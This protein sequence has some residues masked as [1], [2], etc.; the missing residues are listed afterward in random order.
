MRRALVPV[1][2]LAVLTAAALPAT[3]AARP[4]K[5]AIPACP[6]F[7]DP[8]KDDAAADIGEGEDPALDILGVKQSVA[9]KMFSL[10]ITMGKVGQPTYAEGI[11]YA[12]G[13]TLGGKAVELFGTSSL[14]QP[15]MD[16]VF[17]LA[18][19]TVDGTYVSGTEK[20][21]TVT[22]DTAKNTVTLSAS[23]ADIAGAAG[24]KATGLVGG[25][26]A[27]VQGTF[28]ALLEPWDDASGTKKLPLAG[29]I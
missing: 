20:L 8:A 7:T 27:N 16:A 4:K 23:L 12:G 14:S 11:Q 3:A 2:I 28:V 24:A 21:V 1:A 15:A 5:P 25:L 13:F 9:N 18:G 22:K 10:T 26:Q 17:A 6:S 29:C 19:I